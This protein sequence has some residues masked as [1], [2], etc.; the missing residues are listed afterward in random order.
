MEWS[1]RYTMIDKCSIELGAIGQVH[2]N[3]IRLLCDLRRSQAWERWVNKNANNVLP[4]DRDGPELLE[5]PRLCSH[6]RVKRC[7]H[8][9]E[10]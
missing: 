7:T 8:Y 3:T 9:S 5:I 4:H 1:P 6:R 2:P 10:N